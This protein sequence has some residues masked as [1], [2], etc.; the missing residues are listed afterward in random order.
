MKPKAPKIS[1]LD[2]VLQALQDAEGIRAE[3]K[4]KP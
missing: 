4:P 1:G 2:L 3:L